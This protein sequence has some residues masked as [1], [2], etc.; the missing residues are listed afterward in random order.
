MKRFKRVRRFVKGLTKRGRK[1]LELEKEI[2][3]CFENR[4][5]L[6][7]LVMEAGKSGNEAAKK[8]LENLLQKEN[9]RHKELC[10]RLGNLKK[11]PRKP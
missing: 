5:F 8:R 1:L 11:R 7:D 4:G 10:Q 6:L 9:E 3:L 2:D